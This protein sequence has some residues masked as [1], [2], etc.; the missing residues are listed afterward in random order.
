VSFALEFL[1]GGGP[2]LEWLLGAAAGW[3][4]LFSPSYRR[5]VHA[6]WRDKAWIYIAVDVICGVASCL[7]F[8]LLLYALISAF[9]GWDWWA[10][11]F[12][13]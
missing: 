9:A 13:V 6:R 4:Y 3:R 5:R 1:A 7:L 11:L 8:L 10:R 2:L 12:F